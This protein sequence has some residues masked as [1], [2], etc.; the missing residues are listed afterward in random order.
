MN[1]KSFEM[2]GVKVILGDK[3]GRYYVAKT[4]PKG[5]Y[6]EYMEYDDAES[7]FYDQVMLVK[8]NANGGVE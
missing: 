2:L 3:W 6:L 1:I 7:I 8:F 5:Y 4:G